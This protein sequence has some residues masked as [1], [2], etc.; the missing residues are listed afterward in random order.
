MG[1]GLSLSDD[2]IVRRVDLSEKERIRWYNTADVVLFPYVG[3]EPEKLADPPFGILE[4]MSCGRVVLSTD[5]L[6]VSDVVKDGTNGH[7]MQN[8][9]VEGLQEGLRR[10]L[11]LGNRTSV[12]ARAR[13]HI[14]N[15]FDYQ[16]IAEQ[17]MKAYSALLR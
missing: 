8:M 3:P 12:Q 1:R 4:A 16:I 13:E 6:S 17:A 2:L 11:D 14:K 10:A 9:T 15:T 7:L 5:V